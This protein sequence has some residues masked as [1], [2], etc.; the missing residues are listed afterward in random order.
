M[1]VGFTKIYCNEMNLHGNIK[2]EDVRVMYGEGRKICIVD[3]NDIPEHYY[4]RAFLVTYGLPKTVYEDVLVRFVCYFI[5]TVVYP[6]AINMTREDMMLERVKSIL[7]R[8]YFLSRDIRNESSLIVRLEYIN[9]RYYMNYYINNNVIKYTRENKRHHKQQLLVNLLIKQRGVDMIKENE[10]RLRDIIEG[11]YKEKYDIVDYDSDILRGD[12][13]LYNYQKEDVEWMIEIEKMVDDKKNKISYDYSPIYP[14]LDGEFYIYNENIIP[15]CVIAEV[16]NNRV[17]SFKGGN[18]ISEVGV[19]KTL[20]ALYAIIKNGYKNRGL[21]DYFVEFTNDCNYFYKRGKMMG[22]GCKKG[23]LDGSLYCKEHSKTIFIDKRS[24]IYKNLSSFNT[25][26]FITVINGRKYINTNSTLICC[27]NQLCDQWV[28]EYYS[29]FKSNHRVLLIVTKDQY[30][31]ITLGDILFSDII[32]VSYN[33]LN[34]KSYNEQIVKKRGLLNSFLDNKFKSENTDV[35][36]MELLNSKIFNTFDLFYWDRVILDEAHEIESMKVGG[37]RS[38]LYS[39][40][41]RYKWNITGTPFPNKL[42]SFINL[43]TYNTDYVDS[44][45]YDWLNKTTNMINIGLSGDVIEKCKK[46]F[47]RNTKLS[48]KDEYSG[49]IVKEYIKQLEFTSQ[50]R[51]IYDSYLQGARTKYSDFLIKLCC[52]AELNND[53]KEMIKNCKTLNEIHVCMLDYNNNLMQETEVTMNRINQNKNELDRKMDIIMAQ[54]DTSEC[55]NDEILEIKGNLQNLKKGYTLAKQK[56]D[57]LS[58]TYNYLQNSLTTLEKGDEITCPIC[59]DEIESDNIAITKCGHKF[60]WGCIYKTYRASSSVQSTLVKCPSCNTVMSNKDIYLLKENINENEGGMSEL[61][62]IIHDVKSTKIGNII[63]FLKTTIKSSD[64]VILFSQWDELL[65]KVGDTLLKYKINLVYCNGTVYNRKR[66]IS[67]FCENDQI[68]LILLSSRNAASGINLTIANKIIFLEPIYGSKD[69]RID[70]ES[71][72]IGR[73]DR[74]GQKNPIDIYRFIIKDT[75][76][77]DI[78]NNFV[79][80]TKLKQLSLN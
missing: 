9:G 61:S 1:L 78:L 50:E 22:C 47:R 28:Q 25:D 36:K 45:R 41:S 10:L 42:Y 62:N 4:D 79:D 49:N 33:F 19:G 15:S 16:V 31:N 74:L 23:K 29:K 63:H 53:T 60:C 3:I 70:V 75:I 38:I 8:N 18:I 6:Y 39:F 11:G 51:A 17:F 27:P 32:I 46:L 7:D 69:Y 48:I 55:D 13:E 20:V 76:E 40:E 52:H 57:N 24:C 35:S 68:N 44:G 12:I 34:N 64:K 73:A 30:K 5:D 54:N 66:A 21:Y 72:G 14:V 56:Y 71:Q 65:H 80:D 77:Q 26:D 58:R 37:L 2:P 43:M 59:L 67:S